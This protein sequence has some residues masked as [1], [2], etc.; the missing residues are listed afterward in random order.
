MPR[1]FFD[2]APEHQTVVLVD[3]AT[4]HE[5]ERL[6]EAFEGCVSSNQL[7]VYQIAI[8]IGAQVVEIGQ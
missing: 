6:I 1:D 3:A 2:P 4:L 8:F 7:K 5:A